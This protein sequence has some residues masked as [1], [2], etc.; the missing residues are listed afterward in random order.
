MIQHT[1]TEKQNYEALATEGVPRATPPDSTLMHGDDRIRECDAAET[2][3]QH[4]E[5]QE[6]KV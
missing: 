1:G 5:Q 2:R 6:E 3:W 4:K